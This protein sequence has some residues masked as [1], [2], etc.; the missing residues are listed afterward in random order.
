MSVVVG[1]VG[2]GRASFDVPVAVVVAEARRNMPLDRPVAD[3]RRGS[4]NVNDNAIASSTCT[5]SGKTVRPELRKEKFERV[6]RK[7]RRRCRREGDHGNMGRWAAA[8]H[9][10]PGGR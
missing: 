5:S 4:G 1:D 3:E 9:R 2:N 8:G 10:N 7:R 6:R